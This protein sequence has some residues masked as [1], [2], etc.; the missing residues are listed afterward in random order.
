MVN[1]FQ[2]II[3]QPPNPRPINCATCAA[4]QAHKN[5]LKID[6][7]RKAVLIEIIEV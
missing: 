6:P 4:L 2:F 3:E 5:G 7:K 1:K